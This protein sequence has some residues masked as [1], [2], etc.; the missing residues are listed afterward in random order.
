MPENYYKKYQAEFESFIDTA[1]KE[2]IGCGDHSS[3]SCIDPQ[4]QSKAE[5]LTKQAGILGGMELAAKIFQRYDPLLQF[6]PLLTDGSK[7][8]PGQKAFT[9]SGSTLSILATER[10]VLNSL[11]RMSGIATLTHGLSQ[12]IKHTQCKLLD[13]RKTTPNFR[14]AEKWAVLIGGGQNHRMGLFDALMIKENDLA[15]TGQSG[16][17]AIVALLSTMDVSECGAF[18][19][20]EVT[21]EKDAIVAA[22]TWKQRQESESLPQ[23]VLM[24]DNFGP[25]RSKEMVTELTDMGLR[26]SVVIEASGNIIF[27]DLEAWRECGVDVLSTSAINRGTAPL[28]VS[29]LIDQ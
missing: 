5:L 11:Q 3:L 1:L 24:L 26:D 7:I 22:T 9:I 15:V 25:D 28:D 14:H 12:K 13:T 4:S 23:L 19:E 2:D 17:Q 6:D 8:K 10:L 29:M 20:L 21:N 16:M 18:L 27:D